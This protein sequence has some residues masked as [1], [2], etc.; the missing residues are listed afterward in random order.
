MIFSTCFLILEMMLTTGSKNHW[1]ISW[2]CA[3]IFFLCTPV[4]RGCTNMKVRGQLWKSLL[5]SGFQDQIWVVRFSGQHLIYH[6]A[7]CRPQNS[8]LFRFVAFAF[9]GYIKVRCIS[10]VPGQLGLCREPVSKTKKFR[11]FFFWIAMAV[12]MCNSNI[13]TTEVDQYYK[14]SFS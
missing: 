12:Y 6:W 2:A 4:C 3:C 9:H 8:N 1:K 13:Q 5:S 10:W 7:I 14:G 11:F